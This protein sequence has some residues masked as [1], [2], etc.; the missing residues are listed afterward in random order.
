LLGTDDIKGYTTRLIEVATG[1]AQFQDA[2]SK[3]RELA[4]NNLRIT[5]WLRTSSYA[6]WKKVLCTDSQ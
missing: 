3:S 4:A 6:A 2:Q 1:T 5:R